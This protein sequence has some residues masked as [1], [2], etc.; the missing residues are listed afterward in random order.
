MNPFL[1]VSDS[2]CIKGGAGDSLPPSLRIS[3][4]LKGNSQCFKKSE[5]PGHVS[6]LQ[7]DFPSIF[8]LLYQD[9]LLG[10]VSTAISP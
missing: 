5:M 7:K 3:F 6:I 2:S 8:G 1:S 9:F 10:R 4:Q